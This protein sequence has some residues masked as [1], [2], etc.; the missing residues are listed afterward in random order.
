MIARSSPSRRSAARPIGIPA[1]RLGGKDLLDPRIAI[2]RDVLVVENRI[3]IGDGARHECARV[4]G[5]RG[6]DDLQSGRPVEPGFG[7]LAVI[8]TG[9]AQPAPRHAN[10]HRHR[11]TP[12]IADLGGIVHELVESGRDEIVELHLADR[13]VARE[14][15]AD[16]RA[17][18]GT[19]G[20][21][22][23]EDAIA[24]LFEERT[25]QQKRVA[26]RA[27]DVFAED[28]HR[29]VGTKRIA[30]AE[31]HRFEQ[32]A[33][34]AIERSTRVERRK[35]RVGLEVQPHLRIEHFDSL[36]WRLSGENTL[37]GLAGR[38]PRGGNHL[39]RLELDDRLAFGF[40][41]PEL[42]IVD[43]PLRAAAARRRP[44]SGSR[45]DQN[46]YM[47]GSA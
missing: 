34:G 2:E 8:R 42:L 30:N 20:E 17:E 26:V 25:E 14:R 41:T 9:V 40:Q 23:V 21:R 39:L 44:E 15:G 10:D 5:R 33:A 46:A 36:S 32:R 22:R 13:P 29:G 27:A 12:A 38:R 3:G 35:R 6:H 11:S 1:R 31:H 16:A 19:F 7:V 45:A 28:E 43:E 4:G 37:A 24:E 18:H 47:S